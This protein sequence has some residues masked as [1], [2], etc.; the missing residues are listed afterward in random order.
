MPYIKKLILKGFKSFAKH[1]LLEFSPGI[2]TIIGSNGS[3]K[4]NIADAMSFV[5]G[6]LSMKSMRAAKASNLVFLGNK[7]LG[8]A[9]EAIVEMIF[10]NQDRGFY[11]EHDEIS[12]KRM[13]KKNG[14]SLYKINGITKTRQEVLALL[15]QAGID[16]NGFN[17]ILQGKIQEFVN[18]YPEERRKII[19]EVS[20]ISIYESRKEKSLKELEKTQ[21]RLKEVMAVLKERWAYLENLENERQQAIKFK[22]LENDVKNLKAS[23][24]YFDLNIKRETKNNILKDITGKEKEVDEI[25]KEISKLKFQI[26]NYEIKIQEINKLIEKATG[27]EQEKLNNEIANLRAEGAGLE[28]KIENF[29]KKANEIQKKKILIEKRVESEKEV[30]LKLQNE[31]P[32]ILKT[33]K[34]LE[35][36]KKELEEMEKER[37]RFYITKSELKSLTERIQD[38]K[39]LFSGYNNE[40]EFLIKEI[41]SLSKELFDKNTSLEKINKLKE[42]LRQARED[43]E[44]F[45]V[46]VAELEKVTHTNEYEIEKQNSMVSKIAG[47][48]ICP[49]C[50]SKITKEHIG[51]IR[52][53]A[54]PKIEKLKTQILEAEKEISHIKNKKEEMKKKVESTFEEIRKR[55]E[56]LAKLNAINSK[57]EQIKSI[58]FKMG[59]LDKEISEMEEKKKKLEKNFDENSDIERRYE[60]LRIEVQDI[61]LVSKDNINNEIAYK[62]KEI[63]REK[64]SLKE[65]ENE[66]EEICQ[67]VIFVKERYQK[68]QDL[69]KQ[70]RKQEEELALKFKKLF[71]ERDENQRKI[72]EIESTLITNS[73]NQ[74]NAEHKLND[75]KIDKA[76]IEAEI[77]SLESEMLEFQNI[78]LVKTRK[79]E[80]LVQELVK[81][82]ETLSRIGSVNLKAVEVYDEI[83]KE[84]DQIKEKV[85]TITKE[86]D[87]ILRIIHEIDVKKKKTFLGTLQELNEKFSRNFSQLS[88]KGEVFLEI[89]NKK[90]P[91]SGGVNIIN[92]RGHGKYFDIKS[93]SGGEKTV[94]ALSLIFAIQELNPYCFYILDEIDAALDKKNSERLGFLLKR[95]MEKGQYIVITHNDEIITNATHIYGVSMH[96]GISKVISMKL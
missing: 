76:R 35:K 88:N 1:T 2:N 20:G 13:L 67:E 27:L 15:A 4:S 5:L 53:D 59:N 96:E 86:K 46:A 77:G 60:N 41:N 65:L 18:M 71:E 29:E 6:R 8:P 75:L 62:I 11:I 21:E 54:M 42:D 40:S 66:W 92:K 87:S 91:F 9:K 78:S 44:K 32:T 23:I 83:K 52:D 82:Q 26:S 94:V 95:Y 61:T 68:S 17:I 85:E 24:I 43:I 51:H 7:T 50:K 73:H 12:I 79:R 49:L 48:D 25:K 39:I 16:P 3:G 10:D 89:E 47:L 72:R 31:S 90:E 69:L 28:V 80:V 93:L 22:K 30:I 55:E 19:E 38:K 56:D 81:V 57:N 63:D 45:E 36:K 37:K 58:N 34:D 70:K 84:Y 33:Q 74:N 14:Q 64:M